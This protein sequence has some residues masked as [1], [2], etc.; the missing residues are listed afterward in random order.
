[1]VAVTEFGGSVGV[2]DTGLLEAAL[3]RPLAGFGGTRLY[4]TPSQRAAALAHAL[5]QNHGFIDGNKR[6]AMY[7]MGL[8]FQRQGCRLEAGQD[9]L[10]EFALALAEHRMDVA[11]AAEWLEDHSVPTDST[12]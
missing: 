10:V 7:A 1:V 9:E 6:T 2:R 4:T 11:D 5:V 8:W 12:Q 3:A